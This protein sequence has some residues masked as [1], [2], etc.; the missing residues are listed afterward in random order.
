METFDFSISDSI[1]FVVKIVSEQIQVMISSTEIVELVQLDVWPNVK[2]R[3]DDLF[4][5]CEEHGGEGR[6]NCFI[7]REKK[8]QRK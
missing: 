6:K 7:Q 1:S 2:S 5:N 8:N 4:L 3:W